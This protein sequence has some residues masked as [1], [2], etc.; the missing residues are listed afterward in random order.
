M[1]EDIIPQ[2]SMNAILENLNASN[3]EMMSKIDDGI[4]ATSNPEQQLIEENIVQTP[5]VEA[6]LTSDE[7]SRYRNIGQELFSPILKALDKVLKKDTKKKGPFGGKDKK[8]KGPLDGAGGKGG[9][10]AIAGGKM[11]DIANDIANLDFEKMF[12]FGEELVK[13]IMGIVMMLGIGAMMFFMSIG[14]FFGNIWDWIKEFF[15]P[16]GQFFDFQ[17]GPLAGVFTMIGGAI[18]GLWKMVKGVFTSLAK[19]GEWIWNGIK[20]IFE[21]FITGPNGIISFGVKLV[22]GIVNFAGKAFEWIGDLLGNVILGPIKKIF[23]KAEKTGDKAGDKAI[24]DTKAEASD[25]IHKQEMANEALTNST[26]MSQNAAKKNWEAAAVKNREEAAAQA[27]KAGIKT[28]KDGTIS[29]AAIKSKMADDVIKRIED[30]HGKMTDAERAQIKK[31]IEDN[32]HINGNKMEINNKALTAEMQ[33]TAKAIDSASNSNTTA[34]SALASNTDNLFGEVTQGMSVQGKDLMDIY[35]KANAA[36]DFNAMTEEEQFL[37][38]ME[39]AKEQGTLAEFR[40]AEARNMI[41]L[42]MDTIKN[43][44]NGFKTHLA[45]TF[46][47]SF[48]DFANKLKGSIVVNILPEYID[49]NSRNTYDIK[50]IINNGTYTDNSVTTTTENANDNRQYINNGVQYYITPVKKEDFDNTVNGLTTLAQTNIDMVSKQNAVLDDIKNLLAE[51]IANP[52]VKLLVE[53]EVKRQFGEELKSPEAYDEDLSGKKP[54]N[55]NSIIG[56]SLRNKLFTVVS[57]I[58]D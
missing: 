3:A 43:T 11:P 13:D 39:Q 36:N 42:A 10:D 30:R 57:T 9:K 31:T 56:R 2:D 24:A 46:K 44:F 18:D 20:K 4:I 37:W 48:N 47:E 50:R 54:V 34:I 7:Q 15:A 5:K 6:T 52:E 28:N 29:A 21:T 23:G 14:D 22:K 53:S 40:I 58:V 35:A 51:G 1:G 16:I 17:N 12:N 49:D 33:K 8:E 41:V 19:A 32:I 55:T 26:I 45:D 25:A 27:K 38:R